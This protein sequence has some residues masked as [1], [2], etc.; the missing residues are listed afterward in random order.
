MKELHKV[1]FV[2]EE[3]AAAPCRCPKLETADESRDR[4]RCAVDKQS[5]EA[6][7]LE[8]IRADAAGGET[9]PVRIC[10][11]CVVHMPIDGAALSLLGKESQIERVGSSDETTG[12]LEELQT[13]LGEGPAFDAVSLSAPVLIDDVRSVDLNRWPLFLGAIAGESACSMFVFPLQFGAV[14]LGALSLYRRSHG[15]LPG[16]ALAAALRVADVI[17]MLFLGREGDLT[18]DFAEEWLDE[19]SWSREVHQATGMLI[20]QLGIGAE[21]SFVRLRAHAFAQGRPLSDVARD[22]ISR[23]LRIGDGA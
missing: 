14:R 15:R 17:A 11:A 10:R 9:T 21:E 23:R 13:T 1:P 18:E 4:Y 16:T 7:V 2:R 5:P 20:A 8:A 3:D 22:V 12:R 6:A 19:S